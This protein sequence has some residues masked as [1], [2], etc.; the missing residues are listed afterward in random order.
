MSDR[1]NWLKV[2]I[3]DRRLVISIGVDELARA[4]EASPDDRICTYNDETGE[5]ESPKIVEPDLFAADFLRELNHEQED[6]TTDVHR[7]LDNAAV[8]AFE[9]GAEG[10]V[11]PGDQE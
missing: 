4:I 9:N 11:F 8:K 7:L 2:E 1:D 3:A 5:F 6:G 10:V